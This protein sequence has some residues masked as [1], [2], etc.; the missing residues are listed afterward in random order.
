MSLDRAW[1]V[2]GRRTDLERWK[3]ITLR[4]QLDLMLYGS[5]Q[6]DIQR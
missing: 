1:Y 2:D 3:M 4:E 5:R 6:K